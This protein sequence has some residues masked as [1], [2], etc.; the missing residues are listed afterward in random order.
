MFNSMKKN[1]K[2]ENIAL[3]TDEL[4][5]KLAWIFLILPGFLS[6]TC[7][8]L[9]A[10]YGKPTDI[11]ITAYSFAFTIINISISFPILVLLN[12]I[13]SLQ[14]KIAFLPAIGN[15]MNVSNISFYFA[16]LLT[17][18]FTGIVAGI[19][20]ERDYFYKIA[21]I[22]PMLNIPIQDSIKH[23]IDRILLQNQTGISN[24]NSPNPDGRYYSSDKALG[25]NQAYARVTLNDGSVFEGWPLYFDSRRSNAQIYMSPACVLQKEENGF[26]VW[27]IGGPGVTFYERD[28]RRVVFLDLRR[29][30]CSSY[31]LTPP[32]ARSS[33][34]E[35]ANLKI[36][37]GETDPKDVIENVAKWE[38]NQKNR[39]LQ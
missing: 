15:S 36:Y 6:Y 8:S 25:A 29:T 32:S 13:N 20:V 31:W 19:I 1:Q 3:V 2:K 37:G 28:I 16:L 18:L 24:Y 7:A 10:P 4:I 17:S 38:K 30:K 33:V 27:P 9:I 11:E 22:I 34:P 23:P 21:K 5:S 14:R 39:S 26:D 12:K 35:I